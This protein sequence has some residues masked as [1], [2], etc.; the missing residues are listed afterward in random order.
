M[1]YDLEP[2][3][4]WWMKIQSN[5]QLTI[6]PMLSPLVRQRMELS[7]KDSTY[8]SVGQIPGGRLI[9]NI[10]GRSKIYTTAVDRTAPKTRMIL[11]RVPF[12]GLYCSTQSKKGPN[13]GESPLADRLCK[14]FFDTNSHDGLYKRRNYS[15]EHLLAVYCSYPPLERSRWPHRTYPLFS[16]K[17]NPPG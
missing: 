17:G 7:H 6:N 8:S 11:C 16:S 5:G 14:P 9:S 3:H 2:R 4:H 13:S 15:L 12:R 1:G 10:V